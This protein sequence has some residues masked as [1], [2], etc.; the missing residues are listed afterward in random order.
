MS[1][2]AANRTAH[3]QLLFIKLLLRFFQFLPENMS[4]VLGKG[5]GLLWFHV[6][7]YRRKLV[8]DSLTRA[9]RDEKSA[10]EILRIARENFIHYGISLV[11]FLRLPAMSAQDITDRI[12]IAGGE[13]IAPAL[14]KGKGLII[15]CGHTGNVD[16]FSVGQ[17]L[18]GINAHVI[19]R[20]AKNKAV[21][22]YWQKI[23]EEKGVKFLPEKNAIF[24]IFRLLKHNQIVALVFDQHMPGDMGVRVE[25]FG[26]SAATM[27]APALIALKT[28]TPVIFS[29]C[30]RDANGRHHF[31]CSQEIAL[32]ENE[33][34]DEAVRAT[35]QHF[36]NILEEFVRNH[37]EQWLWVHRRWK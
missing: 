33:S 1:N 31:E 4:L 19:T 27:K 26:R 30:Y 24:S 11:E 10:S 36:N 17:A 34:N 32:V 2:A 3:L 21:D 8:I 15:I 18:I 37:P 12:I 5:L 7:R 6:V 23:R 35:T 20:H 14:A 22:H 9:F 16:M 25:F 13:N 28:G 29:G